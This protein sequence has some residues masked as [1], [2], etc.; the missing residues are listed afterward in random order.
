MSPVTDWFVRAKPEHPLA[1]IKQAKKV[2]SELPVTDSVKALE[3]LCF[4]LDSI[5]NTND[6]RTDLRFQLIDLLDQAAKIH[7]RKIGQEYLSGQRLQKTRENTLWATAMRFCKL[8]G[9]SYN[10][11]IDDFQ[12]GS[13]GSSSIQKQL[14]VVIARALRALTLQLKWSLLRYG[15]IDDHIWGE[16]GR[17][18]RFA[19]TQHNSTVAVEVYPDEFGRSS[20]RREF[21]NAMMLSVSSTDA[22]NLLEQD[23]A[24]RAI[25]HFSNRYVVQDQPGPGCTF[26]FDLSMHK[27]PARVHKGANSVG[28]LRYFGAGNATVG[29]ADLI[30]ETRRKERVPAD[31][32]LGG[33]SNTGLVL[34]VLDHLTRYW[35]DLP[36]SRSSERQKVTMRLTVAPSFG[37]LLN[38]IEADTDNDSLDFTRTESWI[39]ENVSGAGYGAIIPQVKGDWIRVGALVGLKTEKEEG[40]RVGI[41]RRISQQK[42]IGIQLLSQFASAVVVSSTNRAVSMESSEGDRAVLLSRNPDENGEIKLLL[43][44]DTYKPRENLDIK[45]RDINYLLRPSKLIER[46]VDFDCAQFEIIQQV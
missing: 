20:V 10:R 43:R 14:S 40:W 39:V 4:W 35:S 38:E 46:G 12:S 29:L 42:R 30:A 18:Y 32:K 44:S 2:I 24:E 34:G 13:N 25:A 15:H 11:C 36:P 22:L 27:P 26:L 19:E 37:G 16:L 28:D 6:F 41:I 1:D 8:L 21:L 31:V 3:L 7:Q 23:I 45:V 17:L 9:A 33:G 5:A